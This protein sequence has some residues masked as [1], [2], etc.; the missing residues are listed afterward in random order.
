M[1]EIGKMRRRKI[2]RKYLCVA[3][4]AAIS[5]GGL[6]STWPISDPEVYPELKIEYIQEPVLADPPVI[7]Y[8]TGIIAKIDSRKAIEFTQEE[9][10]ALLKIAQAEAG[11]QHED[12]C[13]LVMSVVINRVNDESFPDNVLDV[14]NEKHKTKSG[15]VVY[16]FETVRNGTYATADPGVDAHLALARIEQGEVAPEIIA[17]ENKRSTALDKYFDRAFEYKDHRF[18]TKKE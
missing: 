11:N 10:T 15:R 5:I 7:T 16:Q 18:Y 13:W 1:E 12:G 8:E 2:S 17:F 4:L 9:A 6:L 14:I 3:Q